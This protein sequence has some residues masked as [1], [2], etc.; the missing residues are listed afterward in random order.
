MNLDFN[1]TLSKLPTIPIEDLKPL[2]RAALKKSEKVIVVLDDDPT[3]TQTVHD[4]PVLTTWDIDA[5]EDELN[6]GS[7]IFYILTNSRSLTPELANK[8]NHEIGKNLKSVFDKFEKEMILISRSDSTLR[9]HYPN[10]VEALAAGA[11]IESYGNVIVP[12]FFEGGRH[13]IDDVHFVKEKEELVPAA[14]TPFAQDKAFGFSQSNLKKWVEEKTKGKVKAEEVQSISI[15]ILRGKN[16][17]EVKSYL[18]ILPVS[19]TLIVNAS[20]YYDLEKLALAFLSIN[21]V[22]IFRSAASFVKAIAGLRSK[23]LLSRE[24]LVDINNQNGGLVVVG[25]Y[26]PKTSRQLAALLEN[27]DLQSIEINIDAVLKGEVYVQAKVD[28]ISRFLASGEHVVLYTSRELR[29]GK[30]KKSSLQIGNTIAD[31]VTET[32]AGLGIIPKFIIAKGG[33]TSSDIATKALKI[34]RA[35][36]AGQALPGVPVWIP[37]RENQMPYIIFPGNVGDDDSLALLFEKIK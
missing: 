12:A 16:I 6:Q 3:G 9:G 27:K 5:L 22:F 15:D 10:E 30:D 29:T 33:I 26:V 21:S 4:V 20:D 7:P 18:K 24:D 14:D 19:G 28:E 8:L 34:K 23:P 32:V 17:E 25:S 1:H 13:T 36:V 35:L 37:D 31:F 2:I 11:G